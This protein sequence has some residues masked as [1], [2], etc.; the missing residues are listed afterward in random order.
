[1]S[2]YKW[3]SVFLLFF[4]FSTLSA[5]PVTLQ[6]SDSLT[7]VTFFEKGL[8][9]YNSNRDSSAFY[10]EQAIEPLRKA[11]L[12]GHY[13]NCHNALSNMSWQSGN[14]IQARSYAERATQIAKQHLAPV[15]QVALATKHNMGTIYL[16]EGLYEQAG[17]ILQEAV[18]AWQNVPVKDYYSLTAA[19]INY[20]SYNRRKGDYPN[21]IRIYQTAQEYVDSIPNSQERLDLTIDILVQMGNVYSQYQADKSPAY[22]QQAVKLILNNQLIKRQSSMLDCYNQIASYH[23]NRNERFKAVT[24]L[25]KAQSII[26]NPKSKLQAIDK[27]WIYFS[28]YARQ[29]E[30]L[31]VGLEYLHKALAI[32]SGNGSRTN[33]QTSYIH[34][35]IAK[36]AESRGDFDA[37]DAAILSALQYYIPAIQSI[38]QQPR[39]DQFIDLLEG[40]RILETRAGITESKFEVSENPDLLKAALRTY[41]TIVEMIDLLKSNYRNQSA[42]L[43]LANEVII[44]YKKALNVVYQMHQSDPSGEYLDLALLFMEQNKASVLYQTMM[45]QQTNLGMPDSLRDQEIINRSLLDKYRRSLLAMQKNG[46]VVDSIKMKQLEEQMVICEGKL[47]RIRAQIQQNNP[48]LYRR[49]YQSEFPAVADVQAQL[50]D[51]Q[52]ALI[53]YFRG[54]E[55]LYSLVITANEVAFN[56]RPLTDKVLTW[57]ADYH[58][59]ISKPIF[60]E[61]RDS[62]YYRSANALYH[63]LVKWPLSLVRGPVNTLTIVADA[64]INAIPFSAMLQNLPSS[65]NIRYA[66]L[67]YLINDYT[68]NYLYSARQLLLQ[69]DQ[70]SGSSRPSWTGFAPTYPKE[71]LQ[72]QIK[73]TDMSIRG[74][75]WDLPFARNEVQTIGKIMFGDPVLAEQA[76]KTAFLQKAGD[77][78]IIH[79]ATHGFLDQ[80]DPLYHRL[81]F[82]GESEDALYAYEI[83]SLNLNCDMAV[84]S[85]CNTAAGKLEQGEGVMSL[86]RAFT[87]AGVQSLVT[88]QWQI[89]DK[90]SSQI[91]ISFYKY[92]QAGRSKDRALRG[93]QLEFLS[94]Q[95]EDIYAHPYFW[96]AYV[97][98][99]DT[100]PLYETF[101]NTVFLL[102]LIIVPCI[103]FGYFFLLRKVMRKRG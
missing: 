16:N 23:L 3:A 43:F 77:Y 95:P 36:N 55:Y 59:C 42:K 63:E 27:T 85:A 21:A 91:M 65:E 89:F 9:L 99:G 8:K 96:A 93:S 90:S 98:V 10:F 28:E 46:Q 79:L 15:N 49:K 35:L 44:I 66:E 69:K 78:S 92:L 71:T 18:E 41:Q 14:F 83:Y 54:K 48:Q 13:V 84:L 24:Y 56:R 81:I 37:A 7:G 26:E 34:R 39:P 58:D 12:H 33:A 19:Y 100:T 62:L 61:K 60:D 103:A 101:S 40:I 70:A 52:Q 47:D 87:F 86:A 75:N 20:G 4:I 64:E 22:Y 51:D 11:Q 73:L 1:M 17:S 68:L 38:D 32:A 88:T 6:E 67:D 72:Q 30:D 57:I 102:A 80:Q 2:V 25:K 53:E 5:Q 97:T 45:E 74:Q 31:E 82:A 94:S 50:Q 76:S 29:E